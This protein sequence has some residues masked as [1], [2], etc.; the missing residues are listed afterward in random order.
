L[1]WPEAC[2]CR[3]ATPS[4]LAWCRTWCEISQIVG[5]RRLSLPGQ[6]VMRLM[7]LEVA[8]SSAEVVADRRGGIREAHEE[9]VRESDLWGTWSE[10]VLYSPG[11][12]VT[13]S[14][15]TASLLG[16]VSYETKLSSELLVFTWS[17]AGGAAL[18]ITTIAAYL[19][20]RT[21][22][23]HLRTRTTACA[24]L[25]SRRSRVLHHCRRHTRQGTHPRDQ[26]AARPASRV[27]HH[28]RLPP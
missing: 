4:P 5:H 7:L 26:A 6:P 16:S 9:R 15:P 10:D 18:S 24:T 1:P 3:R 2:W 19:A 22:P 28:V 11:A 21:S 13:T 25:R 27:P 20:G 12:Q 23:Q 8:R 17:L 14:T